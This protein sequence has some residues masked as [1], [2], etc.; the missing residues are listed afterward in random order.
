MESVQ[1][2]TSIGIST[3][4]IGYSFDHTSNVTLTVLGNVTTETISTNRPLSAEEIVWGVYILLVILGSALSM[5]WML[6]C[7]P[8][9][10]RRRQGRQSA[11]QKDAGAFTIGGTTPDDA[12]GQGVSHNYV[13][14]RPIDTEGATDNIAFAV[15]SENAS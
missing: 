2:V 10:R 12:A 8:D 5:F 6:Y 3:T 13:P 4:T 14:H 9:S 11:S 1:N 7:R 15:I